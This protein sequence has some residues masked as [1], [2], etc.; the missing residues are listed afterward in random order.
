MSL[1]SQWKDGRTPAQIQEISEQVVTICVNFRRT[2]AGA[3]KS[4][5]TE[6]P[7][8]GGHLY[9]Q[10]N[11]RTRVVHGR[12]ETPKCLNWRDHK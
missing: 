2:W 12:C 10:H 8:C 3:D 5:V 6:C 1:D 7:A 4:H 9:L 11:A